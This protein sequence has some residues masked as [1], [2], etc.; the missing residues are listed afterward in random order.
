MTGPFGTEGPRRGLVILQTDSLAS[1][2]AIG[3][4]DPAVKAGVFTVE[5]YTLA[6]PRNLVRIGPRSRTFQDAALRVLLP[7]RGAG[8]AVP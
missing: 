5:I 2:R 3:E 8:Q 7:R 4:A 6:V 1:A